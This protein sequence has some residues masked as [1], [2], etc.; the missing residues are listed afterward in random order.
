MYVDRDIDAMM[1]RTAGRPLVTGIIPARNALIFAVVLQLVGPQLVEEA[2]AP[3]LLQKVEQYSRPFRGNPAHRG[4]E[5]RPA[6]AA[7]RATR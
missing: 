6:I 2:D 4:V 5:L 7:A 1:E 3:S